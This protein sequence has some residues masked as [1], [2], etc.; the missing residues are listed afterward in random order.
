MQNLVLNCQI[1]QYLL[2]LQA[3]KQSGYVYCVSLC[4]I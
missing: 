4:K 2:K 3:K 1:D